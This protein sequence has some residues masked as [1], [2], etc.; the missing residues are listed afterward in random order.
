MQIFEYLQMYL[1][2]IVH[3]FWTARS[4]V[5]GVSFLDLL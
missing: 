3:I 2:Q 5:D 4:C 1:F